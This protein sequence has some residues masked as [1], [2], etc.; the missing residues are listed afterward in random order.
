MVALP[1]LAANM[2]A[3]IVFVILLLPGVLKGE[4][5]SGT[6]AAAMV[7]RIALN[8][9]LD[10]EITELKQKAQS[11]VC[12]GDG[13][14]AT[15]QEPPMAQRDVASAGNVEEPPP[16]PQPGPASRFPGAGLPMPSLPK[17]ERFE[18]KEAIV[19]SDGEDL[20]L[21]DL[22]ERSVVMIIVQGTEGTSPSIGTGFL[23]DA[24]HIVTNQHVVGEAGEALIVNKHLGRI[25][26]GRVVGRT[27]GPAKKGELDL[28]VLRLAERPS[29]LAPL[30]VAKNGRKLQSVISAGFPGFL[31][32]VDADFQRL[33]EG[34]F[35]A[36]P[37]LIINSGQIRRPGQASAAVSFILHS[38]EIAQGNSGGPL[39]DACA[40]VL[41]VNT[42]IME[43]G[44]QSYRT[45]WALTG[46]ALLSFLASKGMSATPAETA[47]N[48]Q[49]SREG[50]SA[51]GS[52]NAAPARNP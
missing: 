52:P 41:G 15:Q 37:E 11:G 28:A 38:A 18:P 13:K 25:I 17:I 34:D 14:S 46:E 24:D 22:L 10:Q 48:P 33:Q 2:A 43:G 20:P 42:L 8:A 3:A 7:E 16:P 27:D 45:S 19:A 26:T 29:E 47:C 23:I 1:L 30:R 51:S 35:S 40:Q 21:V 32:K 39:V 36:A 5:V 12:V 9:Q 4:S 31:L 44:E 50:E 6:V 49:D